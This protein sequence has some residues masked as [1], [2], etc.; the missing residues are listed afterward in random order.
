MTEEQFYKVP[1][2]DAVDET[3]NQ[4]EQTAGTARHRLDDASLVIGAVLVVVGAL[5]LAGRLFDISLFGFMQRLFWPFYIIVP[6]V[7]LFAMSLV[8]RRDGEG[9]AGF[10]SIVTM[11]GLVLLYQNTTD[12][13]ESW[14]Y[15]WALIAPTSIG[16]GQILYGTL[17]GERDTIKN[18]LDVAKVGGIMFLVGAAFFEL[19]IGISGFGLGRLGWPLMLIGLGLF[20]LV[21]SLTRHQE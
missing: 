2:S 5:L 16:L 11:V 13:W 21:L 6:G 17:K 1:E 10:A 14:A 8:V 3:P 4:A 9:L 7:V 19:V 20:V 18:G 15:A 12:H